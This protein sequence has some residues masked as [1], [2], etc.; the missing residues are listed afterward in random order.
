L[1]K[2]YQINEIIDFGNQLIFEEANVFTAISL[3]CKKSPCHDWVMKTDLDNIKGLI[4]CDSVDYIVKNDLIKKLDKLDK[5]ESYFLIKDV[6]FNYWSEGRGKVRGQSIGSR[7]FYKGEKENS[8]DISY[9][10]GSHLN[11][12]HLA[13]SNNYLR[14]NWISYLNENDT[15]RFSAELLETQP[16]I[17]YRQ[18]S[19][20][21]IGTLDFDKNYNDKTVHIIVNND[22]NDFDLKYV[23]GLFNSQLLNYFFTSLKEEKGRAFSQ[24]KTVDIKNLPFVKAD[25]LVMS[26]VCDN[27]AKIIAAKKPNPKADTTTLES[28]IDKMVYQLYGLTG[29]EIAIIEKDA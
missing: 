19:N 5:F 17:I 29:D 2:N 23:L 10:K 21:L 24:V 25:K 20:K 26:K 27:V 1:S 8:L 12:Y 16:K 9:V 15:F 6:G 18:T 13:D 22:Q 7:V 28:E 14:H 3:I 11:K 4:E